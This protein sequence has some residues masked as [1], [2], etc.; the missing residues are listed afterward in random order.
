MARNDWVTFE[1]FSLDLANGVHNLGADS[2]YVALIDDS[3]TEPIAA[4]ANPAWTSDLDG[5]EVSGTGYS[6]GGALL[7]G[8]SSA[9]ADGVTT[10]DDSGNVTWSQNG[11]GPTDVY[12][13]ILYNDSAAADEAVGFL[14]MGGPVSLID[15]DI[16]ITWNASG[17]LTVT[18]T[19]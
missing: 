8:T 6:A 7:S 12:W 2:F 1:E 3:A 9:E 10:F 14:D 17:I 16:S 13:A 5:N 19:A 4:R 18:V 15:G 11:A